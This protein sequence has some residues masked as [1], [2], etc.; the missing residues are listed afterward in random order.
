MKLG[1]RSLSLQLLVSITISLGMFVLAG[2]IIVQDFRNA[3]KNLMD[4]TQV[5]ARYVADAVNLSVRFPI[6][7]SQLVLNIIRHDRIGAAKTLDER[8]ASLPVL[9][10]ILNGNPLSQAVFIGYSTGEIF[11][12]RHAQEEGLDLG[13]PPPEGA[14]FLVQSKTRTGENSFSDTQLFFD[15]ALTLLEQRATVYSID[16]RKREWFMQSIH[17]DNVEIT[18]PYIFRTTGDIGITIATR[19]SGGGLFLA[20]TLQQKT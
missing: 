1:S 6:A 17:S 12:V 13:A 10:E 16:P 2:I 15:A 7:P 9:V 20:L 11:L 19:V 5:T 4:A 3:S 18:K 8:L 14:V